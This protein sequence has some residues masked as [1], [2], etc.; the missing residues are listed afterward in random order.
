M[1][2]KRMPAKT[3]NPRHNAA[4]K[5]KSSLPAKRKR[6]YKH[7]LESER[8]EGRSEK[9]AKRIAMATV[10]KTRRKKGETKK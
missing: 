1:E 2:D 4:E 5:R 9:V 10:N 6:Q 8:E 7:I 3:K